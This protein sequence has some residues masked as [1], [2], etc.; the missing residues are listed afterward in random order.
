MQ[1][2][3]S[4]EAGIREGHGPIPVTT[5]ER[6]QVGLLFVDPKGHPDYLTFEEHK[7]GVRVNR[8]ALQEEVCLS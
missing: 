6:A 2:S 3:E 8:I 5:H 4:D 1:L 7:D